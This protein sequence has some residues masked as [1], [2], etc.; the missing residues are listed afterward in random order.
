M[1]KYAV[2]QILETLDQNK[3][4]ATYS[5]VGALVGVHP[6]SLAAHLGNRRPLASWVVSKSTGMP[7]D[8][9]TA[10]CHKDLQ[11]NPRVIENP[12]ELIALIENDSR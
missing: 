1:A 7:T 6:R 11:S 3:V 9:L 2:L 10:N 12:D 4:R 8:Y 5:A